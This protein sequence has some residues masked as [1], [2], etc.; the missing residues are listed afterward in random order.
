MLLQ[1]M[2]N[3][4]SIETVNHY[5]FGRILDYKNINSKECGKIRKVQGFTGYNNLVDINLIFSNYPK[6]FPIDRTEFVNHPIKWSN[7]RP[8]SVPTTACTLEDAMLARVNFFSK[9]DKKI[10]IFWS[11]G[12]DST[13][14]VTA[15]LKFIDDK[16]KLRIIYSPWSQYEHPEYLIFL[17]KFPQIEL[18]DQSGELYLDL[19]LDGVFISGLS[20]D[21]IHAS[22]DESFLEEHGSDILD[23]N[24]K[25][26]FYQKN[27][28]D[29]FMEFCHNYF[30]NSGA[31]IETVLDARWLFYATC[32]IDSLLREHTVPFLLANKSTPID[33]NDIYGF[34]N[35]YEYEQ[36]IYFNR[37]KI[38]P[39]N[40]HLQWRQYLKDF[41]YEFD[42]LDNWYQNK[43]KF[44]SIQLYHYTQK[45][46]AINNK[47]YIFILDNNQFVAT[48]NLPFLSQHE[49]D[50]K[51][52]TQLDYLFND[53]D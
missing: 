30:A 23:K 52:H 34:F 21:E 38:I 2:R 1:E 31:N 20:G 46:I 33:L 37:D 17:K 48:H 28:N 18:I 24:W 19:N 49:F 4:P 36:F 14:I 29:K 10:N 3:L 16:S 5:Y 7:R 39:N 15:F 35:F 22:I 40:N 6:F 27:K 8:W 53:P 45:K 26:L 13:T 51:Y 32:K 25:D 12:I 41:C 11:G 42:H 9:L 43:T 44:H 47:R 50:N